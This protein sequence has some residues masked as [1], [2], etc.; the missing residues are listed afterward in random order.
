[1]NV[2]ELAQQLSK[3]KKTYGMFVNDVPVFFSPKRSKIRRA[4]KDYINL[5]TSEYAGV[6]RIQAEE[7]QKGIVKL[8]MTPI[9]VLWAIDSYPYTITF[10]KII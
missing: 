4:L 3:P 1:M 6:G 10:K 7:T 8:C 5:V 9:N 2:E